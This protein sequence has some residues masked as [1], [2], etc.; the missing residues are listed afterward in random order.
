MHQSLHRNS[1]HS[2]REHKH[3]HNLDSEGIGRMHRFG[4]DC[5]DTSCIL[6]V[7]LAPR[8]LFKQYYWRLQCYPIWCIIHLIKTVYNICCKYLCSEIDSMGLLVIISL[9]VVLGQSIL[10]FQAQCNLSSPTQRATLNHN[11]SKMDLIQVPDGLW[12]ICLRMP[13]LESEKCHFHASLGCAS[14]WDLKYQKIG[15]S[16]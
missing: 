3:I 5:C 16:S 1:C 4:K 6:P 10:Q 15:W 14:F 9:F 12:K 11:H 2:N 7:F 13:I 8:V